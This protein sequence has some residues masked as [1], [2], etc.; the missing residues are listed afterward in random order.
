MK[1]LIIIM[2]GSNTLFCSSKFPWA[3]ERISLKF[4]ENVGTRPQTGLPA[5]P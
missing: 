5:L 4:I 3:R 2:E 1:L